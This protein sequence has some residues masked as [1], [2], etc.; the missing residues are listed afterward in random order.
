MFRNRFF[1]LPE[2]QSAADTFSKRNPCP[3]LGPRRVEKVLAYSF[4]IFSG[5]IVALFERGDRSVR[6][7]GFQS[8][9]LALSFVPLLILAVFF[10][11]A[12][13]LFGGNLFHIAVM[14]GYVVLSLIASWLAWTHHE[15]GDEEQGRLPL[16]GGVAESLTPKS[17]RDGGYESIPSGEDGD[18]EEQK[19][20]GVDDEI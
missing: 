2:S 4:G 5:C 17:V 14:V 7:H 12:L 15:D 11:W 9:V 6:F 20:M 3:P 8:I 16:L 13:P 18:E 1:L 10:D 19:V